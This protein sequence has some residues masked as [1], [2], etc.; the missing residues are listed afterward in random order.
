M[1][2]R[3][4]CR[5]EDGGRGAEAAVSHVKKYSR[6]FIGKI[7]YHHHHAWPETSRATSS[8]IISTE[9]LTRTGSLEH[10]NTLNGVSSIRD[11]SSRFR[12]G[13]EA[14]THE[15]DQ[16]GPGRSTQLGT[17]T[18]C[19][20]GSARSQ[21]SSP[22]CPLVHLVRL[23]AVLVPAG[24]RF[25]FFATSRLVRLIVFA[26]ILPRMVPQVVYI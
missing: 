16:H 4:A 23:P 7:T 2:Y 24:A 19:L 21:G 26:P 14:R 12:R 17:R 8:M 10:A 11:R 20:V 22:A 15:S 5:V 3:A 18:R 1:V 13:V 6:R 25:H 9:I